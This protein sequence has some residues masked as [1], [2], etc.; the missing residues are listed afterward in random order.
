M[1]SKK[2][3]YNDLNLEVV[4]NLAVVVTNSLTPGIFCQHLFLQFLSIC[5]VLI[6]DNKVVASGIFNLF[7]FVFSVSNFVFFTT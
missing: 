1:L 2:A 3:V 6:N 7:T 5:V 4:I